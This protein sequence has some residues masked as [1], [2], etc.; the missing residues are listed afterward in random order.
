M[1]AADGHSSDSIPNPR[2]GDGGCVGGGA[3]HCRGNNRITDAQPLSERLSLQLLVSVEPSIV[4]TSLAALCVPQVCDNCT[5]DIVDGTHARYRI[6]YPP[7][8][9]TAGGLLRIAD[10]ADDTADH[11]V[12]VPFAHEDPAATSTAD[13][14]STRTTSAGTSASGRDGAG[15]RDHF[16]GVATFVW[17]RRTPTLVDRTMSTLLVDHAVRVVV[18]RRSEQAAAA[19][20]TKAAHLQV[21]LQNSRHIGAAVGILMSLHKITEDQAFGLLR[22]A[23]QR[24]NRKLR[25]LALD[26]IDTGWLDPALMTVST[27]TTGLSNPDNYADGAHVNRVPRRV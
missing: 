17:H 3:S 13:A 21:A 15:Q 10:R 24:S 18:S 26:V 12:R 4:F 11:T 20:T 9:T 27:G 25:D 5:I 1:T 19:A 23:S 8:S 2:G 6:V 7:R 22:L 14:S 16:H